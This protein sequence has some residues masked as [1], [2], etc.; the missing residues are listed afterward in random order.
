MNIQ[1]AIEHTKNKDGMKVSI[2]GIAS[3]LS[4]HRGSTDNG[5]KYMLEQFGKHFAE[6]REAWLKGDIGAVAE[7]FGL[8]V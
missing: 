2:T 1:E 7:F 8:Y 5:Q 4:R 6:A 3:R